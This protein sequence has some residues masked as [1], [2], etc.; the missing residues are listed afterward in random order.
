MSN[1][2]LNLN[3]L[4][5]PKCHSS[6]LFLKVK[7]YVKMTTQ[8]FFSSYA[9]CE[10]FTNDREQNFKHLSA[11]ME[12]KTVYT[13]KREQRR[14]RQYIYTIIRP[15]TRERSTY[16]LFHIRP[17]FKRKRESFPCFFPPPLLLQSWTFTKQWGQNWWG[18]SRSRSTKTWPT[19]LKQTQQRYRERER[20]RGQPSGKPT[21]A[22]ERHSERAQLTS[23]EALGDATIQHG[24]MHQNQQLCTACCKNV[25][26]NARKSKKYKLIFQNR[27]E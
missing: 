25:A 6:T 2:L 17:K 19:E 16:T 13:K 1:E 20:E 18:E 15:R 21:K 27:W 8:K 26:Y 14:T 24:Y 12:R 23:H 11:P 5:F 22:N 9:H 10:I 4:E 3:I 7:L